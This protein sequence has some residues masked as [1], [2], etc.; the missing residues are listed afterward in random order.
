MVG[1]LHASIPIALVLGVPSSVE[2]VELIR[3]LV[4]GVAAFS[5]IVQSMSMRYVLDYLNITTESEQERLYDVL[6]G[7]AKSVKA[8]LS[9]AER[10]K[11]NGDIDDKIYQRIVSEYSDEKEDLDEAMGRLHRE[12]PIL[13]KKQ[14]IQGERSII[15]RERDAI[16]TAVRKGEISPEVGEELTEEIYIKLDSLRR[17]ESTVDDSEKEKFREFWREEAEKLELLDDEE[18]SEKKESGKNSGD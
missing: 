18:T 6:L 5:L 16:S 15:L 10:L 2:D 1:G 4:Y 11:E 3:S 9:E 7:R 17:G 14:Q 8:A 12:N 13:R